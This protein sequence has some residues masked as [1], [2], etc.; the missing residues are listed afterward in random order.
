MNRLF[1]NIIYLSFTLSS[2]FWLSSPI[3]II[4][5][6]SNHNKIY[7]TPPDTG[8]PDSIILPYPFTDQDFLPGTNKGYESKLYLKKPSNIKTEEELNLKDNEVIISEKI[9][10]FHYRYPQ[11]YS[12]EEYKKEK[13]DNALKNYWRQ[14]FAS[15]NFEHKSSIIPQLKVPSEVFEQIFGTNIIDIRPQGFAELTFGLRYQHTKNNALPVK[16]RRSTTFDFN[17]KIQMSVVGQIGDKLKLTTNFN[18]EATFEFENKMKLAYEGKE[19]EII[20]KIE[21]G[22]VSLPLRGSL[23]Q[24]SYSLFGIKTQLQFG[25]LFVSTMFAQQK[26]KTQVMEI[27]GGAIVNDFEVSADE[28]EANRHFFLN[29]FFYDNYDKFLENLPVIGGGITINRIEVWITNKQ[30]NTTD[31]RNIVAFSDLGEGLAP[32]GSLNIS[33]PLVNLNLGVSNYPSDTINSL[34]TI[35]YVLPDIRDITKASSVLQQYGFVQGKDFEKVESMRMLSPS[36]YTFNPN[37]GYISLNFALNA[38]EILAVAYEYTVGGKVYRVGE[39]ASSVPSPKT[40]I[41]KLVKPASLSPKHPLWKLM[42]KNI[43]SIGAYQINKEDFKLDIFYQNDLT[44]IATPQLPYGDIKDL[45]LLE[46]MNLDRLNQN[47]EPYKDGF[48]DFIDKIT[49]NQQNGRI[50]FPVVEPFGRHLAKKI[51]GNNPAVNTELAQKYAFTELYD[52]TQSKAQ[53]VSEKNKFFLKGQYK[54]AAGN[55]ISL[56]AINIPEGSVKVTAGGQILQE[57]IDYTVDYTMGKVKIINQGIL[58]SGLPIKISLENRS[59]FSIQS[60]TLVGTNLLYEFNKD[61]SIGAT[62]INLTERPLT[63]KVN[64]GDEP[65]SNTIWGFDL[66]YKKD[67]PLLTKFVDKLPFIETKA[68]SGFNVFGEFAHLIPGHNKIIDKKGLAYIDDFEGAKSPLS[69]LTATGWYYAS[70]PQGQQGLFP[71]ASVFNDL[72][73]NSKRAHMS[74][75]SIDQT[76]FYRTSSSTPPGIANDLIN[77]FTR[78]VHETELW[79]NK[80]LPTGQPTYIQTLNLVF[81]P[82]E[83][84]IYNYSL[85]IDSLGR[86]KNPKKSWNGIMRPLQTND[87]EAANYEFIEFWL[88]DPFVYDTTHSGGYLYFNL[89]DIS[90]DILKDGRKSFENGFPSPANPLVVDTTT[91]GYVPTIQSVVNGF[92]NNEESRAYQDIGLDGLKDNQERE[93]FKSYLDSIKSLFGENS[94]AYQKA[95]K[96]VSKDNYHYY[97]GSDYDQ[98][99]LGILDRYKYYN[100]MEG[101]S[102]TDKQSP[103]NYSTASSITPNTE[104]I[105][106][107]NTLNESENYFQYRIH[108]KPELMQIGKNYIVDEVVGRN[109]NGDPVKWYQFRIPLNKPDTIVGNIQD[110]KSI[111]F[112]RMFLT[113]FEKQV[114]LRFAKLDIVRSEWRKYTDNLLQGGLY[115]PNEIENA[116]FDV[117]AVNIEENYTKKP[118]N[119]VLPPGVSRVIDPSN[120]QLRELNEQA[121]LLKVINLQDGDARAVYKNVNLDVRQYKKIQMFV[122]AEAIAGYPLNNKDLCVFLRIGSD[123]Q[124]NYYEYEIPL[125]L[126]PYGSYDKDNDEH[127]K[128]VWP[129]ENMFDVD[130]DVFQSL[131]QKRNDLMRMGNKNVTMTSEYYEFFEEYNKNIRVSIKG[132]PNLSNIKTVMIGIRNRSKNTNRDPDDGLPK[133]VEVWVNE[134]RLADFDNQGGWASNVRTTTKLADFAQINLSGNTSRRGFGSIEK[135]VNERQKEDIYAYDISSNIDMSKF[136]PSEWQISLPVF[137]GYNETFSTPQYNPLNPD[138][139]LKIAL[140]NATQSEKDSILRLARSYTKRKSFNLTNIRVNKTPKKPNPVHISNFTLGYAYSEQYM[141]NISTEYDLRKNHRL[142]IAYNFNTNPKIVEPFKKTK[143]FNKMRLIKDFNFYY[144]PSQFSIINDFDRSYNATKLRNVQDFTLEFPPTYN[145]TF[146]WNRSYTMRFDLTRSLRFEF[147]ALNNAI[148]DEPIKYGMEVNKNNRE[149]YSHWKDSVLYGPSGLLNGGRTLTYRHDFN[150]TYNVPINKIKLFNWVSLSTRYGGSYEWQTS[151]SLANKNLTLGNTIKNSRNIQNSA[152]FNMVN[153]YTKISYLQKINQKYSAPKKPKKEKEQVQFPK[154]G[155]PPYIINLKAN[156]PKPIKHNLKTENVTVKLTKENG[157]QITNFSTKIVN[158]NRLIIQTDSNYKNVTVVITG[159]REKKEEPLLIVLE[160]TLYVLM[161]IKSIS[162]SYT[163]NDGT[164]LPGYLPR[165][166]FLGLRNYNNTWAPGLPFI[167]GAQN[168]SFADIAGNRYHWL[169]TD[170]ILNSPFQMSNSK[171]LNVRININPIRTLKIDVT[172]SRTENQRFSQLF[173]YSA[174]NSKFEF[175]NK[176]YTGSFSMSFNTWRTSFEKYDE[177][178]YSKTFENFINYRIRISKRLAEKRAQDENAAAFNYTGAQNLQ[179]HFYDGYSANSQDVIIPAFL[180]AYSGISPERIPLSPF[181][182]IL[183]MSPNWS[184]NFTGL[185]DIKII[186][187]YFSSITLTHSYRSTYNIN[188]FTTNIEYSPIGDGLS[189]VRQSLGDFI[190]QYE[191]G[192]ITISEQFA[193]FLS[194]NAVMK[195]SLM[196]NIEFK[197]NKNISLNIAN[198]QVNE[199]QARDIVIGTGYRFKD[200]VIKVNEKTFKSD[201]NIRLNITRRHDFTI[202]RKIVNGTQQNQITSGNISFMIDATADYQLG[203]SFTVG[204]Y[205]R[206]NMRKPLVSTTFET[207][208]AE[209]GFSVKFSLV[210]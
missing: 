139:E 129:Q 176:L 44:G 124:N 48:F 119:Y 2:I 41:V 131:K 91:W 28:Y 187:K 77:H 97:R 179:T 183:F 70:T 74:F 155:D 137:I 21:A 167:L 58:Q 107:D 8:K 103:E 88:M 17:E 29:K 89:G 173:Q 79:P 138:I 92:D 18:T 5:P 112:I 147:N 165:T 188:S 154:Q 164:I 14:R 114:V 100:G 87:F 161:G 158:E 37:L 185:T 82:N 170:S 123:Y 86:L 6:N 72:K 81:Y 105:N 175:Q 10:N 108:L 71:E 203:P 181:L 83:P 94:L 52:S 118:V 197:R 208:N 99:L 38:D 148:I 30:G 64:I 7:T 102:P 128:I 80:Q 104:D 169:T 144:I 68:Q 122:H 33:S 42:M 178:F 116:T 136:F 85:D 63:Q 95:L 177:R 55:E 51:I 23:I 171:S 195:N 130:F 3:L 140:K 4:Q 202:L 113:G 39:F 35:E 53:Q 73:F 96:D 11:V 146:F 201:L 210:P 182:N 133:S 141:R 49:V 19:D 149:A 121:M 76:I 193:P 198:T 67:L 36:E 90:E 65:I 40:L 194:I 32:D 143:L 205:A 98:Q 106:R 184:I 168:E 142:Q 186:K 115:V 204:L 78:E 47:L 166:Q 191:I 34:S 199:M 162:V 156:V 25:K 153:L 125:S 45:R 12:F 127:R 159:E 61:F 75:F 84:G 43:Y 56:N 46:V 110:F 1:L 163:T 200:L 157:Q 152:S 101:N 22:D 111:R 145:K 150:L 192:T 26:G 190:P 31:T 50:I 135:K 60:K 172:A 57:N 15:E 27:Q 132:N 174:T 9:G 117:S 20:K 207:I 151:P 126:T 16:E 69:L 93:F 109:K 54:S 59:L 66:S 196:F 206:R 180:S 24:G 134:L 62:I 13:F 209:F 160:R 189:W 120:P